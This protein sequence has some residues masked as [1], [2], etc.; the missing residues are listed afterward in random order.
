M[1][2]AIHSRPALR[3]RRS[4][5]SPLCPSVRIL[6]PSCEVRR[7]CP[8]S[9]SKR[10]QICEHDRIRIT[11]RCQEWSRWLSL[12]C[13]HSIVRSTCKIYRRCAAARASSGAR[14]AE[15]G[16]YA[17]ITAS[18]A[19]ARIA[20]LCSTGNLWFQV[21]PKDNSLLHLWTFDES[22]M[23]WLN[24]R[25]ETV[26]READRIGRRNHHRDQTLERFVPGLF[27]PRQLFLRFFL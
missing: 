2:P 9:V 10:G 16:R 4:I 11:I 20:R 24:S 15:D 18:G 19:V 6:R 8:A 22:R 17:S 14:S 12:T 27:W 13:E 7:Q 5:V 3:C 1:L 26:Q 21:K 25:G 23:T